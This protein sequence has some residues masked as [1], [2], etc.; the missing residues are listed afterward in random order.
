MLVAESCGSLRRI[1]NKTKMK[2]TCPINNRCP[3]SGHHAR[4]TETM[5]MSKSMDLR[6]PAVVTE[7]NMIH[8][9][10]TTSLRSLDGTIKVVKNITV[11]GLRKSNSQMTLAALKISQETR[12]AGSVAAR[13]RAKMVISMLVGRDVVI[14][15]IKGNTT[16]SIVADLVLQMSQVAPSRPP[17]SVAKLPIFIYRKIHSLKTRKIG[18]RI[19]VT[20]IVIT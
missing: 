17:T 1:R 8:R 16:T 14:M 11:S 10:K 15:A 13:C 19:A 7:G 5:I 9:Q 20:R 4:R 18:K 3:S 2:M 6:A 12:E